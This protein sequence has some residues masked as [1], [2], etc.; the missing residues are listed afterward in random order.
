MSI[1]VIAPLS[2]AGNFPVADAQNISYSS[3]DGTSEPS[4]VAE[5]I[6]ALQQVVGGAVEGDTTSIAGKLTATLE[7]LEIIA[8]RL[9]NSAAE[10]E[11]ESLY[12]R[13]KTLGSILN[14]LQNYLEVNTG[15]G[16][17]E[18]V[19]QIYNLLSSEDAGLQK[20]W[21][22]A[23]TLHTKYE[24]LRGSLDQKHTELKGSLDQKYTD[25]VE[26]V[27]SLSEAIN[28]A[29]GNLTDVTNG[30]DTKFTNFSTTLTSDIDTLGKSLLS[31]LSTKVENDV[32]KLGEAL[33]TQLGT[34]IQNEV[35]ALGTNLTKN[36]GDLSKTLTTNSN[37][38]NTTLTEKLATLTDSFTENHTE[39]QSTLNEKYTNLETSLKSKY[40]ELSDKYAELESSLDERYQAVAANAAA[41]ANSVTTQ[42][43]TLHNGLITN[44]DNLAKEAGEEVGVTAANKVTE[45]LAG[46]REQQNAN[47][48]TITSQIDSTEAA[49]KTQI[50][51]QLTTGFAEV[52]A[53]VAQ[54]QSGV[55]SALNT[56]TSTM[57]TT[58]NDVAQDITD[59]VDT[60]TEQMQSDFNSLA[61]TLEDKITTCTYNL[62]EATASISGIIGALTTGVSSLRSHINTISPPTLDAKH[63]GGDSVYQ[64]DQALDLTIIA[65]VNRP[66]EDPLALYINDTPIEYDEHSGFIGSTY[67]APW[68]VT[69][70][71]KT[72][73]PYKAQAT[74][75]IVNKNDS[76][77]VYS[78]KIVNC[79]FGAMIYTWVGTEDNTIP[80]TGSQNQQK[81]SAGHPGNVSFI[82]TDQY[83]YY[84]CPVSYGIPTFSVNGQAGGFTQLAET[85]MI[86]ELLYN[87][88]RSNQAL[89]SVTINIK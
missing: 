57:E 75:Q 86:G 31:G 5:A 47:T 30:L 29:L 4:T 24:E 6:S 36:F 8:A 12:S 59:Q 40:E 63:S 44:F 82:C 25:L 64:Y 66:L 34:K 7:S 56:S 81:L 13:V 20:I 54:I 27:T 58:I 48:L 19:Q 84:A 85:E 39:L 72:A 37:T 80:G 10:P 68:H 83:C 89:N 38:L 51:D 62:D 11:V 17:K 3:G 21:L 15:T 18:D 61:D 49:I 9:G 42:Y 87:I 26:S 69:C 35:S 67:R 23:T 28:A 78:E 53:Q 22:A 14:T 43:T 52:T 79:T 41:L 46:F 77:L 2:P 73:L 76:R 60:L 88:Y 71:D 55:A 74:V 65:N 70:P 32:T 45:T 50:T 1:K 33:N 16:I